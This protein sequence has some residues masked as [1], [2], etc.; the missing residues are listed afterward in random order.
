MENVYM[1]T[2]SYTL[3]SI[4]LTSQGII[5]W[6]QKALAEYTTKARCCHEQTDR[7]IT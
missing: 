1:V 7:L 3:V 4:V 5:S 2:E 6:S